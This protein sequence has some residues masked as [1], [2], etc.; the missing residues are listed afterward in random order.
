MG[1]CGGQ[2]VGLS[3]GRRVGQGV[4][5]SVG[6]REPG[7]VTLSRFD[8]GRAS[9]SPSLHNRE[10]PGP[11]SPCPRL[12]PAPPAPAGEDTDPKPRL[13]SV[14]FPSPLCQPC[15]PPLSL[16]PYP[17]PRNSP[18]PVHT[19]SPSPCPCHPSSPLSHFQNPPP[20]YP[21]RPSASSQRPWKPHH[22]GRLPP[23]S[24]SP[25]FSALH[26]PHGRFQP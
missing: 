1:R 19:P 16:R 2:G 22:G 10:V 3:V 14:P 25:A 6:Q 20:G 24:L 7:A 12:L 4:G 21:P 13:G 26:S 8:L 9:V 11:A 23:N 18:D 17:L 15:D 5:L